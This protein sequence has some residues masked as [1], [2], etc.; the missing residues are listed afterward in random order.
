MFGFGI[1]RSNYPLDD[2]HA[3]DQWLK[4]V[5]GGTPIDVLGKVIQ[6]LRADE[7][8][9]S[10]PTEQQLTALLRLDEQITP[11]LELVCSQYLQQAETSRDVES[12][13]WRAQYDTAQHFIRSYGTFLEPELEQGGRGNLRE[14][15]LAALIGALRHQFDQAKL[16]LFRYEAEIP[17]KYHRLHDLYRWSRNRGFADDAVT[18]IGA[19]RSATATVG[20]IYRRTLLLLKLSAGNLSRE[21]IQFAAEY[22]V[23][24]P[25]ISLATAKPEAPAF[26][27]D[28]NSGCGLVPTH[29]ITGDRDLL[30]LNPAPLISSVDQRLAALRSNPEAEKDARMSVHAEVETLRRLRQMWS[31]DDPVQRRGARAATDIPIQMAVGF[32]SICKTLA[33]SR[34]DGSA[35]EV[36][37]HEMYQYS[38]YNVLD[39]Y[40]GGYVEEQDAQTPAK[41]RMPKRNSGW[42]L[43]DESTS[44]VR[45]DGEIG[46]EGLVKLGALVVLRLRDE[47]WK[48]AIVRRIKKLSSG[49]A[50]YGVELI[51]YEVQLVHIQ[52]LPS[53]S[54]TDQADDPEA[55]HDVDALLVQHSPANDGTAIQ[56]L[57]LPASNRSV[58]PTCRIEGSNISAAMR[59]DMVL[60]SGRDWRWVSCHAQLVDNAST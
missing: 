18:T 46:D 37:A 1:R 54:Q 31:A 15:W 39:V 8:T 7:R 38:D 13:S 52:S 16:R 9:D 10:E 2:P 51:G 6:L 19:N 28:L 11:L 55:N 47:A 5:A 44:G 29:G 26:E 3:V 45:V 59:L 49:L 20:H 36:P 35:P 21:Q 24:A 25:P 48:P 27:L 58:G 41:Y 56:S 14:P 34:G 17:A 22:L 57:V 30:Y 33:Q 12:K 43:L 32:A 53:H 23:W 50:E 42:R 60:A 40:L 4:R